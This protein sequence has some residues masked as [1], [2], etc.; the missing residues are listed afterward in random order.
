VGIWPR[1]EDRYYYTTRH[2]RHAKL[3]K[4]IGEVDKLFHRLEQLFFDSLQSRQPELSKAALRMLDNSW[5]V[6]E[7]IF[8]RLK[9]QRRETKRVRI[10]NLNHV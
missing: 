3:S 2:G 7:T 5:H 8:T 1:T 6:V 4:G 9:E 10:P